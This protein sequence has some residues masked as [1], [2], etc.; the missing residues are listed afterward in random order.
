MSWMSLTQPDQWDRLI[1]ALGPLGFLLLAFHGSM[2][3]YGVRRRVMPPTKTPRGRDLSCIPAMVSRP[4]RDSSYCVP[5]NQRP[6]TILTDTWRTFGG[7][8]AV[9]KCIDQ[10]IRYA[11]FGSLRSALSDRWPLHVEEIDLDS[12]LEQGPKDH[13]EPTQV[14]FA[15]IYIYCGASNCSAGR[16]PPSKASLVPVIAHHC[17]RS[18]NNTNKPQSV[19]RT[20]DTLASRETR[21]PRVRPVLDY[22]VFTSDENILAERVFPSVC[23][24]FRCTWVVRYPLVIHG[25][26]THTVAIECRHLPYQPPHL[27]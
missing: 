4:F 20:K 18:T 27:D 15:S 26:T 25:S 22:H 24:R 2:L 10:I 6:P 19:G 14:S 5:V 21:I 7:W 11:F 1:D 23:G 9:P 16:R 12:R 3:P 8:I 17:N 13:L